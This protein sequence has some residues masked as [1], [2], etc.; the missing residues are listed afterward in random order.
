M[1]KITMRKLYLIIIS[2]FV[3]SLSFATQTTQLT[4]SEV[5]ATLE[6]SA[7]YHMR[8]I[9]VSTL[10]NV[11]W[12][13]SEMPTRVW[14]ISP[15]YD[16]MLALA[17]VSGNPVYWKE[18]LRHGTSVGW[19]PNPNAK[20]FYH[21]DDHA[22]G[23]AWLDCYLA[24]KSRT[25]RLNPIKK[26]FDK[27]INDT[28][29][30]DMS[31]FNIRRHGH[32]PLQT[33]TWCDALF[34]APPTLVR[35][36]VI[37][38][39]K[40]YLDYM[41]QEFKW[42]YD[43]M[44]D[45]EENLFYRDTRFIGKRTKNGKKIIWSRGDGWVVGGLTQV[46]SVLPKDEP[47][48][49]FYEDLF[50]AMMTKIVTLQGDDGLWTVNLI[51]AEDIKGGETSGS[52][53]FTYALAWGIN[54]GYLEREK[55]FSQTIKAWKGLLTRI[56]DNGKV[57]YV[58]PVGS[59]PN[60]FSKDTTHA[61]G[62]GAFLLAGS[63]IIKLLGGG[64]NVSDAELARRAQA[65]YDAESPQARVY[66][67]PRRKDDVAWEN[68]KMAFRVYGPALKDSIENS[69]IDIWAK[70]VSYPVVNKWYE[71]DFAKRRSYHKDYGEGCD[72]YKVADSVGL[73]GTGIWKNGKLY[74]SNVYAYA[75]VIWQA[76]GKIKFV[77]TYH[78][79]VEG[80][81]YTEYKVISL[82]VGDDFC[83][84]QSKF[85]SG[86]RTWNGKLYEKDT[87]KDL[88]VAVGILAQSSNANATLANGNITVEDKMSGKT[89]IVQKVKT[90]G[91]FVGYK[92]L[93]FGKT[94]QHLAILKTDE[95]GDI[96]YEIGYTLKK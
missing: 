61:Y 50:V 16:G 83:K 31:K 84:V 89:S 91:N 70:T 76:E 12:D 79:N 27:I 64:A 85:R 58:Q 88:E 96:H 52:A 93:D 74:Q 49:K 44:F 55:Y 77:L 21:A 87:V 11:N 36:Y 22:V 18:V 45:K 34:M 47:S 38:A 30:F 57:G 86:K 53:F 5:M 75:D 10:T 24:D 56:N 51:D 78:Y 68:D 14:H 67:E 2:I 37:T 39:D 80:K 35:L 54:N 60:S 65:I 66:I 28:K 6:K 26:L 72:S 3:A 17:R 71:D 95:N 1:G 15:Y 8:N 41:N 42:C 48:R 19:T 25:E 23:H 59:K 90:R 13:Y 92:S 94:K 82:K 9:A 32:T 46:I 33:W 43:T 7:D 63:E 20:A 62:V 29:T 4:V 40:K 81:D 73:G 69:G